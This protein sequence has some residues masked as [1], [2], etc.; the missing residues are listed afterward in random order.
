MNTLLYFS[1]AALLINTA[2]FASPLEETRYCTIEPVRTEDG[3]IARRY[4]VLRAFRSI[5]PCPSTGNRYGA[6]PGWNMD[7]VIPLSVGGCD[8]VS[9]LQWL[10]VE[11]KR[12]ADDLCKDRWERDVYLRRML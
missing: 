2:A 10:P 11:I 4:D 7:H 3:R 8:S 1:V 12:C 5:H 6:C 9:N